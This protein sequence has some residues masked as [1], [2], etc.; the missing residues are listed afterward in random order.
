M[1]IEAIACL[2]RLLLRYSPMIIRFRRIWTWRCIMWVAMIWRSP[3]MRLKRYDALVLTPCSVLGCV[4]VVVLGTVRI[5]WEVSWRR[6]PSTQA[7][8]IP[9]S[10]NLHLNIWKRSGLWWQI[11]IVLHRSDLWHGCITWTGCQWSEVCRSSSRSS[12]SSI[13]MQG[14]RVKWSLCRNK[15]VRWVLSKQNS[16]VIT[17]LDSSFWYIRHSLILI[18]FNRWLQARNTV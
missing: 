4:M 18:I 7:A 17:T 5:E 9:F 15:A 11:F 8:I 14:M 10:A 16:R 6:K 12:S 3:P 2:L 13:I 1:R